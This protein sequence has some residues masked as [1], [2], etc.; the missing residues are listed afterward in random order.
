MNS[1][2]MS[3]KARI[4]F[5]KVKILHLE[6]SSAERSRSQF[7]ILKIAARFL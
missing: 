6:S 5:F 7:V 3:L 4:S 2:E 1:R